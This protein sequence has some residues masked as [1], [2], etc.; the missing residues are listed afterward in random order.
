MDPVS[1]KFDSLL[2]RSVTITQ[3][4]REVINISRSNVQLAIAVKVADGDVVD[5]STYGEPAIWGERPITVTQPHTSCAAYYI[6][7]SVAIHVYRRRRV[8]STSARVHVGITVYEA[9]I[10]IA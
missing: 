2:E 4:N 3:Q 10:A 6:K 7:Y 5:G 1:W 8:G 9:A